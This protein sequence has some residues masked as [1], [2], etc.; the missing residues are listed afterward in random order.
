MTHDP[1]LDALLR[2]YIRLYTRDS[3]PEWREL[4]LP[5]FVATAINEDGSTTTR[6]LDAFYERQQGLFA[7]GKPVSEA[8]HNTVTSRTGSLACVYSEYV[9]TDGEVT[10]PG[11]LMML[12][13]AERGALKIQSLT[14]S[15]H[16]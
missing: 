16:G 13:V 9:W 10:R 14:F 4:F 2:D 1:E 11:R 6:G 15:Y 8:L 12:V 5:E 3:L 7:T